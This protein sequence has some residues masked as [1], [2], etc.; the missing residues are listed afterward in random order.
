VSD[1]ITDVAHTSLGVQLSGGVLRRPGWRFFHYAIS[2]PR[3]PLGDRGTHVLARLI[4]VM[5]HPNGASYDV[6]SGGHEVVHVVVA[7]RRLKGHRTR[8]ETASA[9]I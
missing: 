6:I 2:S 4:V 5:R 8:P 9:R 3:F 1:T 7:V